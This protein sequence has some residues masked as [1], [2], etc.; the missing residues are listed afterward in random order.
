VRV[1]AP[2]QARH[3]LLVC[4]R[5]VPVAELSKAGLRD[6]ALKRNTLKD[7]PAPGAAACV[8]G[9]QV[10]ALTALSVVSFLCTQKLSSLPYPPLAHPRQASGAQ[11]AA[12]AVRRCG[13][14]RRWR[15]APAAQTRGVCL[16][17]ACRSAG[18]LLGGRRAA[19]RTRQQAPSG[20]RIDGSDAH[21]P[22]PE[23]ARRLA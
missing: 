8:R 5:W 22:P 1:L 23:G 10:F 14:Q 13:R 16:V 19:P 6:R 2:S 11:Q 4:I 9:L 3:S 20:W 17:D 18:A 7:V 21:P 12:Q 15:R